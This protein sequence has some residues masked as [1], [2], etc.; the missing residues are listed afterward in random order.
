MAENAKDNCYHS[1]KKRIVKLNPN[2]RKTQRRIKVSFQLECPKKIQD[3]V[4]LINDEN[5]HL[6]TYVDLRVCLR[7]LLARNLS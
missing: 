5:M 1:L 4:T 6:R 7:I 3:P 2:I